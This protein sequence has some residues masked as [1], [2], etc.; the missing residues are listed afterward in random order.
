[1]KKLKL[2]NLTQNALSH[3]K[4]GEAGGGGTTPVCSYSCDCGN[5]DTI[6]QQTFS[7][8]RSA[9]TTAT[10]NGIAVT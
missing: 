10:K 6:Y 2:I 1:M 7:N 8:F 4:G 3:I 5:S 9:A